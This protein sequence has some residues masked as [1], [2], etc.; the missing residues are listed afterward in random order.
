MFSGD[1]NFF[2]DLDQ[3]GEIGSGSRWFSESRWEPGTDG[4]PGKPNLKC[5]ENVVS[6]AR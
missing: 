6:A 1:S 4:D 5:R 2:H 3:F